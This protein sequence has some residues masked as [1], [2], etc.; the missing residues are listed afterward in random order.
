MVRL[1]VKPS[2][3]NSVFRLFFNSVFTETSS[4]IIGAFDSS[5][6]LPLANVNFIFI[7]T[8]DH[9]LNIN[10]LYGH[11]VLPLAL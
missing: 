3:Y 2:L 4:W 11:D 5:T 8:G 9:D 1:Q 6:L 7:V 10:A